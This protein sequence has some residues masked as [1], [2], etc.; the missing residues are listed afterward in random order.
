MNTLIFVP[1]S[2]SQ[3]FISDYYARGLKSDQNKVLMWPVAC[4]INIE[5]YNLGYDVYSIP[6]LRRNRIKRVW[7]RLYWGGRLFFLT[8]LYRHIKAADRIILFVFND[9][10]PITSKIIT[11]T[12]RRKKENIVVIIDEGAG[13]Y[14][15]KIDI[16]RNRDAG[17]RKIVTKILGSEMQYRTLGDNELIDCAL[18]GDTEAYKLLEKSKKQL[19]IQQNNKRI[20]Q[21]SNI[22]IHK[23]GITK[24]EKLS[25]TIK[26]L[27]ISQP[28][29]EYGNLTEA[30]RHLF[31]LLS[32][33]LSENEIIAIKPHPDDAADKYKEYE[34]DDEKIVLISGKYGQ[35]PIESIINDL[36]VKLAITPFS[37]AG[38]RLSYLY[39]ELPCVFLFKIKEFDKLQK[40]I[41]FEYLNE[42]IFSKNR[43]M[44]TPR[45][46]EELERILENVYAENREVC[47]LENKELNYDDIR[48]IRVKLDL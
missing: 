25:K 47:N 33:R 27:Y 13:L 23:I 30:E 3:F 21:Q 20:Y 5:K 16:D 38:I 26:Y 40:S 12:K 14:A 37:S 7:Q 31:M 48:E 35:L 34:M 32:G 2:T 15:D 19:I 10:D 44:Y 4:G 41:S 29:T 36:N 9:T 18:V 43:N 28:L 42:S 39:D 24:N 46:W 17:I 45:D 6:N 8:E 22:L 11:E 1:L